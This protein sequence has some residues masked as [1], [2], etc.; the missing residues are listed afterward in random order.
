M[1]GV[2]LRYVGVGGGASVCD[3]LALGGGQ[4]VR[5]VSLRYVGV[6]GGGA[7]R[8]GRQ[9]AIRWRWGRGVSL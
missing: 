9:S 1:R 3:T 2:S 6:G 4:G 5:G 8:E 7:G